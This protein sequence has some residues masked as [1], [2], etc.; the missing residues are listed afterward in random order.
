M[1]RPTAG[2]DRYWPRLGRSG[3]WPAKLRSGSFDVAALRH[4]ACDAIVQAA[5][6]TAS[7][8]VYRKKDITRRG[9]K[10]SGN[11]LPT[12]QH[13]HYY[14]DKNCIKQRRLSFSISPP[15]HPS[16]TMA[17]TAPFNP[18]PADLPGKPFV[19]TWIPPPVTQEKE[20]FAEL[21]SIDL[22]LLDSD[23]PAVVDGLV[24]KVK[25]AIR[26]DGF[27]F[28]ENYGISL[29]QVSAPETTYEGAKRLETILTTPYHFREPAPPPILHSTI[30]V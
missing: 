14:N 7:P 21:S 16:F 26:N 25:G 3:D 6:P 12:A 23:D 15:S 22:S 5:C 13:H 28:L 24:Q 8:V 4:D 9:C 11:R 2:F 19:K 10:C 29:E 17:P 18:P 1:Q 27:L 20:N 30:L